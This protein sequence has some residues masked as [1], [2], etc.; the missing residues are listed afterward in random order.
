MPTFVKDVI[1]SGMLS[2]CPDVINGGSASPSAATCWYAFI[3]NDLVKPFYLQVFRPRKQGEF[4]P[5]GWDPE[6]MFKKALAAVDSMGLS[7]PE[8]AAAIY[9]S[10]IVEHNLAAVG[11]NATRDVV[12]M[13]KHFISDRYRGNM[14]YGPWT[15]AIKVVP[16]G[17]S[18]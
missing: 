15:S 3:V 1:S 8:D 12:T 6:A 5:P 9:A 18:S 14:V 2:G 4:S 11:P 16:S 17:V 7:K 10:T 13:E